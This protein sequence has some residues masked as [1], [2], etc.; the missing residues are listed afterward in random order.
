VAVVA[1]GIAKF[2]RPF[3]K[4]GHQTV[5]LWHWATK[6]LTHTKTTRLLVFP[7]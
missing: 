1:T 4:V 6:W 7:L 2:K 3:I 5:T